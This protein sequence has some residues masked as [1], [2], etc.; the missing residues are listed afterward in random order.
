M[1]SVF[2]QPDASVDSTARLVVHEIVSNLAH[3]LGLR[4]TQLRNRGELG[5]HCE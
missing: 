1:H 5:C 4:F 3:H 2:P